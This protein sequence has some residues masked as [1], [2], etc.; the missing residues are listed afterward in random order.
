MSDPIEIIQ[1]IIEQAIQT[2]NDQTD[3]ASDAAHDLIRAAGGTY[4]DPPGYLNNFQVEAVEPGIPQNSGDTTRTFEAQLA[5]VQAMLTAQLADFFTKYY[6]LSADAFDE[7][8]SWIVNKITTG[9]TRLN[10]DFVVPPHTDFATDDTTDTAL[11][12]DVSGV[13]VGSITVPVA[14]AISRIPSTLVDGL[15]EVDTSIDGAFLDNINTD[16]DVI[17][18]VDIDEMTSSGV[19]LDPGIAEQ[20][21]Q[22]A[23]ERVIADGRRT[24][25]QVA[26]G[27]AAKGYS[28]VPGSMLRKMEESRVAQLQATGAAST[29]IAAKHIAFAIEIAKLEKDIVDRR[30]SAQLETAKLD[31]DIKQKE[32]AFDIDVARIGVQA[33]IAWKQ[34][35]YDVTLATKKAELEIEAARLE[36]ER[37]KVNADIE[38][39]TI[40]FNIDIA[41]KQVEFDI[42]RAKIRTGTARIELDRKSKQLDLE[43]GIAEKNAQFRIEKEKLQN[44]RTRL[45]AERAKL[46]VEIYRVEAEMIRFAI[47]NAIQSRLEA[48]KAAGDYIRTMTVAPDTAVKVA[49]LEV[50]VQAKM[51]S[52]ASDFYR[53]RLGRDE[54]VL[55]SKLAET[56][57][58]VEVYKAKRNTSTDAYRVDNTALA[59]A[60]DVYARTASAAL[61]SLNSIV[62]TASNI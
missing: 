4:F 40:S 30:I 49:A 28:M 39:K 31:A 36:L 7:A 57:L 27:Y 61:S 8:Q 15:G 41:A 2:A 55:K 35:G 38:A 34:V 54:L 24:E 56:E 29:D 42:E 60:A 44:E 53:A 62:S 50:D 47:E 5:N 52:A 48:M 18:S 9:G 58:G 37:E 23:R 20:E 6:P 32:I 17:Y 26:A 13:T 21:W 16:T 51:M 10:A 43:V 12:V 59:A 3:A 33:D 45:D 22:R 46:K 1:Q 14:T 25:Q 11:D 19:G